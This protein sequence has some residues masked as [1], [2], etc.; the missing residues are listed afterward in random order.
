MSWDMS[1]KPVR[2]VKKYAV[3]LRSGNL[4]NKML[5]RNFTPRPVVDIR[6]VTHCHGGCP[7]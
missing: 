2:T 7:L 5:S 1:P 6:S 4:L 3:N